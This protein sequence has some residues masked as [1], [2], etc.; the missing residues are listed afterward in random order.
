MR[1]APTQDSYWLKFGNSLL[2]KCSYFSNA[3]CIWCVPALGSWNGRNSES[4]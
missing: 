4:K 1:S 3:P 2:V